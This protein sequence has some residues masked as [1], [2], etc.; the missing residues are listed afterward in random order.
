MR[1]RKHI[2]YFGTNLLLDI[3]L[4]YDPETSGI[5]PEAIRVGI[6]AGLEYVCDFGEVK[7]QEA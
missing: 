6:E 5:L 1:P 4:K 2:F 7:L 3:N